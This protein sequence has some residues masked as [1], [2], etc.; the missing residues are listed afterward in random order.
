MNGDIHVV[1]V[2]GVSV[3]KAVKLTNGAYVG[4]CAFSLSLFVSC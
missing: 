4:T 1:D 3:C 2:P